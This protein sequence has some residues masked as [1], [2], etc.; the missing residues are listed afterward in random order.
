M[1]YYY[2]SFFIEVGGVW[3]PHQNVIDKNPLVWV[4]DPAPYPNIVRLI[5]WQEIEFPLYNKLVNNPRFV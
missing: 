3:E 2:I 4:L 1:K 5:F